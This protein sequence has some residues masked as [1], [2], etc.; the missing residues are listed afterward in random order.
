MQT[1]LELQK[2]VDNLSLIDL[3]V[4]VYICIAKLSRLSE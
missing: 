4:N 3:V 2:L 1:C